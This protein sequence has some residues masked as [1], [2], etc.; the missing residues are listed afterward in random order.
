MKPAPPVT[1]MRWRF[2]SSSAV[3][4]MDLA[5]KSGLNQRLKKD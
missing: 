2:P 5:I 3:D 4:G 1:M